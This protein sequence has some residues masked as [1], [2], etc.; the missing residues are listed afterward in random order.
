MDMSA[1]AMRG[2]CAASLISGAHSRVIGGLNQGPL[3]VQLK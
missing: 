1:G 3:P 2:C